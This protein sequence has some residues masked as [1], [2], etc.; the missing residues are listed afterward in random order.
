M[1]GI[2]KESQFLM[3][4]IIDIFRSIVSRCSKI[5]FNDVV[6][7]FTFSCWMNSDYSFVASSLK[8]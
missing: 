4:I 5:Q 7:E 3:R 6:F 2:N 8:K 1:N